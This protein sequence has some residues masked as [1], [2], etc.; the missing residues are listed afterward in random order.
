MRQI[1]KLFEKK[2][3]KLPLFGSQH[4][5]ICQQMALKSDENVRQL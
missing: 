2:F 5:H 3:L 1:I 4:T